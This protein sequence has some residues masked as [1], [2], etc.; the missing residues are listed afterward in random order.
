M[1]LFDL[2]DNID[3]KLKRE[4]IDYYNLGFKYIVKNEGSKTLLL[5][6]LKPRKREYYGWGYPDKYIESPEALPVCMLY[7]EIESVR[8][9][10]KS[11]TLIENLIGGALNEHIQR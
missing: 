7:G 4:L 3:Y 9:T 8:G 10:N 2:K 11:P 5:F 6:S 1:K